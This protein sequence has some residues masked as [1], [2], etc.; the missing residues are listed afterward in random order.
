MN[1]F[2]SVVDSEIRVVHPEARE[3]NYA[4]NF[5][6]PVHTDI[7]SDPRIIKSRKLWN[8]NSVIESMDKCNI[9]YGLLSGL[10][11]KN[12]S[13]LKKN[14]D[15]VKQC[16]QLHSNKFRGLYTPN[17]LNPQRSA[18]EIMAL[19]KN[20]YVG[21]ELIPKWQNININLE[22]LKPIVKAV[23]KRNFF[24][25]IYT[26]HLTQTLDGDAPYRT[27]QFL[28]KNPKVRTLIP[29][30]GGMLCLY[31]LYSPIRKVLKNAYFITSVSAT[32]KM[33]KFAAEV[34]P[35]NLLFGTDFPFNHCFNQTTPLKA[36]KK[37]NIP[38]QIK[39]QILGQK[40]F[41]LFNFSKSV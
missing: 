41:D 17:P 39:T 2:H 38:N 11:W 24:L 31:G 33:T 5:K 30:L 35:D 26:A 10:A 34:N 3:V 9:E 23:K 1:K 19:D 37:M 21:V 4:K 12:L 40:A 29:H 27:L 15:Y 36:L 28:K 20:L 13:I 14:N 8:I 16:L 7:Y 18:D 32:M 25:K 6:E 22:S